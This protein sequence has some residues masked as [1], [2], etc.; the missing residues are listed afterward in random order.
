[1]SKL[2]DKIFFTPPPP[3]PKLKSLDQPA[4]NGLNQIERILAKFLPHILKPELQSF[5]LFKSHIDEHVV[6]HF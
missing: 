1:M 2:S 4:K 5:M 3:P 6:N